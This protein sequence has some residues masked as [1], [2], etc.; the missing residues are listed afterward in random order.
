MSPRKLT[1][2]PPQP[3]P[4]AEPESLEALLHRLDWTVLRPLAARFGGDERSKVRGFGLEMTETRE[5]QPGDDVR[6]ID[7]NITARS[8]S[9]YVRESHV[10]RSLDVWLVLDLSASVDWGTARCTKR[11][12]A[13]EFVAAVGQLLG[14]RGNRLGAFVFSDRLVDLIPPGTGRKHLL[15]LLRRIREK[16]SQDNFG[17]PDFTQMLVQANNL[18]RGRSLVII[19][20][21][22]LAP[23]GWQPILGRL[24]LR[25]EVVAACLRD[26]REME[27]P[28]IGLITLEDPETGRQMTVDTADRKLRERFRQAAQ[29]QADKLK[30]DLAGCGV[31]QLTLNT[32]ENLLL[33][34]VNFLE[35]R[36]RRHPRVANRP[37]F[38]LEN[39][40]VNLP[41]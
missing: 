7:W 8:D 1:V 15:H 30:A 4:P 2:V 26:P 21:D 27:L 5:Y 19:V 31:E 6:Y 12:L 33:A 17:S 25:H 16:P 14:R 18:I 40:G 13:L 37:S 22:F 34:L 29:H 9:T 36:Q 32:A 20:S 10:E 11:D 38:S 41:R 24:A 35:S 3:P 28:D 23:D 39:P